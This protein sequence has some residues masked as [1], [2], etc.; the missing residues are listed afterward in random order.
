MRARPQNPVFVAVAGLIILGAD[1]RAARAVS[2]DRSLARP[3]RR[4]QPLAFEPNRGQADPRIQYLARGKGYSVRLQ[5]GGALLS[6]SPSAGQKPLELRMTVLG[7]NRL[8]PASA[9]SEQPG[10]THYLVGRDPAAWRTGIPRYAAVRY[11]GVYRGVDLMYHGAD[12]RQLEYDFVVAPGADPSVIRL[13]F[14]GVSRLAV[15]REGR[16]VLHAAGGDVTWKAPV[17]YQEAGGGRTAVKARY[18]VNGKGQV[19]FRVAAYDNRRPLVIDPVL[20]YSTYL[21]GDASDRGSGIAVD[22]AGNAYVTGTTC[23]DDFA[24]AGAAQGTLAGGCDAFVTKLSSTGAVLYSTYLGGTGEDHGFGI[25]VDGAGRAHVVGQTFSSDFPTVNAAQGSLG[26]IADA[27]VAELSPAGDSLVYSTYLGGSF[28]HF[29]FFG[30]ESGYGLALDSGGNAYVTGFT[31]SFDFPTVNPLQATLEGKVDAF[32]AKLGPGGGPFVYSTYLAVAPPASGT[33]TVGYSIAVD[34]SGSAYVV[35]ETIEGDGLAGG[36]ARTDSPSGVFDAFAAKLSPAGNALVYSNLF[37][38]LA[39]DAAY[40]VAVDGAGRAVV[41]GFT[42]ADDFPTVNPLQAA[43][44]GIS[45]AFVAKLSSDGGSFVYS[46]YLGGSDGDMAAGVALDAAGNA[47]V[48]GVTTSEDF[49]TVDPFQGTKASLSDAFLTEITADGSALV[50]STYYGDPDPEH[51]LFEGATGVAVDG[52]GNV[53]VA[54]TVDEPPGPDTPAPLS[55]HGIGRTAPTGGDDAFVIKVGGSSPQNQP[56]SCTAAA[57]APAVL[58]SPDHTLVPIA[59][60]GVSDPDGDPL[61]LTVGSITQDEIVI[62]NGT[63]TGHTCPD[64][65]GVGTGAPSVRAERAGTRSVPGDG[66]VYH[67]A[68]TATDPSGASC[69][70]VATVCVPHDLSGGTCVDEGALYD[71]TACP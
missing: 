67:I 27:Y 30:G 1:A 23:S 39:E 42:F 36:G 63:G 51:L 57:A 24:T 45:D 18:E 49:P 31:D 44:A 32:V 29:G 11:E 71:S 33:G 12:Q 62:D 4:D 69:Q 9:I 35:G 40:A 60:T 66:R 20:V 22:G 2:T 64:A 8:A 56:P 70:G 28:S 34:G 68:F 25:A 48:T 47:Y 37:G 65:M 14:E 13:G 46:T 17:A 7:A 55:G 19:R 50:Y 16:L 21:R 41:A 6:V 5:S 10:R 59:V 26:G 54:G 52:S 3:L 15:D 61:V 53:Y 43:F 38:G 58:W